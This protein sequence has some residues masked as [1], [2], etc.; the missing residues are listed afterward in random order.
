MRSFRKRKDT[1]GVFFFSCLTAGKRLIFSI[2]V[3]YIYQLNFLNRKIS[4][5]RGWIILYTGRKV[6]D[7]MT[8]GFCIA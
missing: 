6:F 5:Q 3:I 8:N 7:T 2:L 4:L 1:R